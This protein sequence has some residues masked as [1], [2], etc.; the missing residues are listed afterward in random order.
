MPELC[1]NL[2]NGELEF[3]DENGYSYDSGTFPVCWDDSV[4]RMREEEKKQKTQKQNG[5]Y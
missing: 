3:I 2:D 4:Y 1:L 5:Q